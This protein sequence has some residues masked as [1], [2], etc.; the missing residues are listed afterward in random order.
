MFETGDLIWKHENDQ[1]NMYF[2]AFS[3]IKRKSDHSLI[4]SKSEDIQLIK[5]SLDIPAILFQNPFSNQ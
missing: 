1:R 4:C 5:E 3:R 2:S